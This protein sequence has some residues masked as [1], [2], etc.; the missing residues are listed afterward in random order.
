M[1]CRSLISTCACKDINCATAFC[2]PHFGALKW[3]SAL[4]RTPETAVVWRK[5]CLTESCY[6]ECGWLGRL[7][8]G[9]FCLVFLCQKEVQLDF[10]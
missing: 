6:C 9:G 10:L 3:N 2:S 8:W 5:L 7:F 4:T 1:L